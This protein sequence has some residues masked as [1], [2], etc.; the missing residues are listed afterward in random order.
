[1]AKDYYAHERPELVAEI[2]EGD[3]RI[4]DLGCAQGAM[5]SLIKKKGRANEIWGVEIVEEIA[6]TAKAN[7]DLDRVLIGDIQD[8]VGDLP[9]AYFSHI[10]AGDVL[11]HLIDP[12]GT[13]VKLRTRL[14]PGGKFIGSIPNI[15]NVSF[16]L[17]LIFVGKF[18]YRDSGVMD[19]THLRFF[20]RKDIKKMFQDA[21]FSDIKIAAVR[22][23]KNSFKMI[24][25][26]IFRDFIIK[27]FLIKASNNRKP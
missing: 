16:M 1:M 11:E 7:K 3:N 5:S 6:Q 23:K 20:T 19:R 10:L 22:K 24:A 17:K 13:L 21:G 14:Q 4:L 2:E 15:R 8:I 26:A 12:W 18:E 25:R 9:E 27:G